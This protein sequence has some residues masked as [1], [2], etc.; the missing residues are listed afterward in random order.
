MKPFFAAVAMICSLKTIGQE[1]FL[2]RLNDTLI[3]IALDKS[4]HIELNGIKL[5]FSVSSKDELTYSNTLYSFSYPKTF[6]VSSAQL[7]PGINQISILTAEGTG[8]LI[9]QYESINPTSLKELMLTE[10]T[11]ESINYGY[12]STRSI[13]KRKLK[14][15]EEIEVM[16][17][18][19]RYKEE[20]NIYEV[21]AVGKKDA[22]IIII[23][24][25]MDEDS[26]TE[27]QKVIDLM[28]KSLTV[29]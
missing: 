9:Q 11:K 2:I 29:K 3:S 28:W 6:K 15:G 7:D 8:F 5:N 1:D 10:M 19:L 22:G 14:S 17:A 18:D 12:E 25:R 4:Y 21:A 20:V 26:K 16:K 27:G 23:T 24:L 13:Y